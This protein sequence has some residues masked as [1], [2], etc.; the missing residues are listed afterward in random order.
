MLDAGGRL[1]VAV[2]VANSGTE[3]WGAVERAEAE[4][5]S[6]KPRPTSVTATWIRVGGDPSEVREGD[7][8]RVELR[9]GR[10]SLDPG[11]STRLHETLPV[12]STAGRWALVID[13]VNDVDGSFAA[14]GSAPAVAVYDVIGVPDEAEVAPGPE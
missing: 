2:T 6:R 7:V 14:L 8:R 1:E 13:L 11:R 9:V 4:E 5:L 3:A 12:P 10:L